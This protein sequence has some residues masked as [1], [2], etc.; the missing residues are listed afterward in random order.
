[1]KYYGLGTQKRKGA[2]GTVAYVSVVMPLTATTRIGAVNQAERIA[3][4]D[5]I[6][7]ENVC[8]EKNSTRQGDILTK[9]TKNRK[10]EANSK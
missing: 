10:K 5:K 4:K 8:V 1:M 6:K 7:L 2:D 3:K 9:E